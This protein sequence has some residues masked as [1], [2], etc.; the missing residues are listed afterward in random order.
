MGAA[1]TRFSL[2]PHLRVACAL[3]LSRA[4]DLQNSGCSRRGIADLCPC[5]IARDFRADDWLLCRGNWFPARM[6]QGGFFPNHAPKGG[7]IKSVQRVTLPR[8]ASPAK[9]RLQARPGRLQFGHESEIPLPAAARRVYPALFAENGPRRSKTAS[10]TPESYC[11]AFG[12][13]YVRPRRNLPGAR[14]A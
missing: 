8:W 5:F 13:P 4:N 11:E 7:C 3:C 14:F 10:M 6:P 1:G 9:G 12:R 2:R